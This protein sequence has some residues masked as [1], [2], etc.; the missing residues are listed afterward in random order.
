[1]LAMRNV[2]KQAVPL[3]G[4][5]QRGASSAS[6]Q[7][8]LSPCAG[9]AGVRRG[10]LSGDKKLERYQLG[11]INSDHSLYAAACRGHELDAGSAFVELI[12]RRTVVPCQCGR[13]GP[14]A[15]LGP[16]PARLSLAGRLWLRA[17]LLQELKRLGFL[18]PAQEGEQVDGFCHRE[19][20][21]GRP[22]KILVFFYF[23][24]QSPSTNT[25]TRRFPNK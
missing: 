9:G 11:W 22:E 16:D 17:P 15:E 7:A 13:G 8:S 4:N 5:R 1:M 19:S 24:L 21:V 14:V 25:F 3:L 18:H 10:A 20:T 23:H 12:W 6:R 2:K